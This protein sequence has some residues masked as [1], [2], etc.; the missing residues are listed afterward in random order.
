MLEICRMDSIKIL[1]HRWRQLGPNDHEI[2]MSY[3]AFAGVWLADCF[4]LWK[5]SAKIGNY[6]NST[7]GYNINHNQT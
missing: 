3:S 7:V 6:H 4:R 2:Q 5:D 1:C